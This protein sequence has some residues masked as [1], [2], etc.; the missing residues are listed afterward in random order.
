METIEIWKNT[1]FHGNTPCKQESSM[2]VKEQ[3]YDEKEDICKIL[4]YFLHILNSIR[5]K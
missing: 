2:N 4:R 1:I 5:E 3:T